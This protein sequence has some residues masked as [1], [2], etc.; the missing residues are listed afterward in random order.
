M[1]YLRL[2]QTPSH[3]MILDSCICNAT[4]LYSTSPLKCKQYHT[5]YNTRDQSILPENFMAK[6]MKQN[7][8]I[9]GEVGTEEHKKY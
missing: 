9:I 4:L 6:A 8:G 3:T 2:A 1:E 5:C 7:A